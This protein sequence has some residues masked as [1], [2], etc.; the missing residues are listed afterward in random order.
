M[1]GLSGVTLSLVETT[2]DAM[3]FK[4]WLGERRPR[5]VLGLDTETSGLDP[6]AQDAKLRLIQFG[7]GDRG[8]AIPWEDW[9]G[10]AIEALNEWKGDW[11]GH[12]IASFDV[13]WIEEHSP[14]RFQAHRVRDGMLAAHIIDP[15]GPG[16][17]KTLS[18]R[19]VDPRA[20]AGQHLLKEAM[21]KNGWTWGTVPV[22]LP[23]Y[24]QYGALD[25]ILS[26][27]L[28]L[29]QAA[30]VGQGG[31]YA[32]TFDLEMAARFIVTRM[33]QRGARI[34]M[35]YVERT[36]KSQAVYAQSLMRWCLDNYKISMRKNKEMANLFE[37]LGEEITVYSEK[38]GAKSV[39]KYQMEIFTHSEVPGVRDLAQA[40]LD[41]RRASRNATSYFESLKEYSVLRSDGWMVHADIRTLA[42]RTSRMSIS[43]P[44][45]QQIPKR[46]ALVRAAFIARE[47]RKLVP[48][49]FDQVEMRLMAH[50]S[51]DPDLQRAFLEA[52]ATG[53]DFFTIMGREIYVDPSFA[54]SDKRRGLVKNTL[55]GK[56]YGAGINKMS[57]SAGVPY[58]QMESVVHAVDARY[59][60][61]KRFMKE[62]EDVGMRRLREEGQGYVLT[63]APYSRKL[64]CDDDK[65]YA[66]TNYLHQGHAAEIFKR[67]LIDLDMAGWGEFMVLPVHDEIV[68]DVPDEHVDEAMISVPKVMS[69]MA[70]YAVPLTASAEGPFTNWGEKYA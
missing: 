13:R 56:A 16:D 19:M 21:S 32:H 5:N 14:Y 53:G 49:D 39:D 30:Q 65:V 61:I 34:D 40:V 67:S 9:R 26:Y 18:Q 46:D 52:D 44:P 54:R 31:K 36:G 17:L 11:C 57:E 29:V 48:V 62:I 60:G 63:P 15:L 35:D 7:D 69:N 42:A 43:K 38:T 47:G 2:E 37:A 41:M 6:Y 64:P 1:S 55:Y 50:F 3:E 51:K 4:R 22:N 33:Q 59:P 68:L 12:N 66:L 27:K 23:V 20:A 10:L 45:L 28:D 70:D 24:W 25:P 8:W 58:A